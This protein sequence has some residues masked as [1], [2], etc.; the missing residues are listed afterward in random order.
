VF[1]PALQNRAG[2]LEIS[3]QKGSLFGALCDEIESVIGPLHA[4]DFK[5]GSYEHFLRNYDS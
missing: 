3:E 5:A 4:F 2:S 1:S